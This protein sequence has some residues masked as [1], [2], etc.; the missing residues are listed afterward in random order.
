L[1]SSTSFQFLNRN[2]AHSCSK[3]VHPGSALFHRFNSSIGIRRIHANALMNLRRPN[4]QV[5]I[6]QSEFG[7]FMPM[8]VSP[9]TRVQSGFNSSIGIRRIHATTRTRE[10]P[11]R[12]SF[13]SSIGIRRI[14]ATTLHSCCLM[15]QQF[16]FL[17]RNSAHSCACGATGLTRSGV[18]QFLNRNSA[19]SCDDR[20]ASATGAQNVSIPQSEFGAFMLTLPQNPSSPTSPFQFLNRNSA[21]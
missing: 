19:H 20:L 9:I 21:H 14:H 10:T 16:Q 8:H 5:S 2:S 3:V 18:F 15:S 7:A 17:N 12:E 4:I 6:P 13:N 1:K 11:T